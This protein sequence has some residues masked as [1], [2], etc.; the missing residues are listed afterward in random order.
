MFNTVNINWPSIVHSITTTSF[1][2]VALGLS[3]LVYHLLM[4]S[5]ERFSKQSPESCNMKT[6]P[7]QAISHSVQNFKPVLSSTLCSFAKA[8]FLVGHDDE[9]N[10][11]QLCEHLSNFCKSRTCNAL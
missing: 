1:T 7:E 11:A 2:V 3:F 10:T 9:D 5:E 4:L 8:S 6:P